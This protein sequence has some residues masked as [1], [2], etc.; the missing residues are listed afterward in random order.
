[1]K[2]A[3]MQ[4]AVMARRRVVASAVLDWGTADKADSRGGLP[5]TAVPMEPTMSE[6]VSLAMRQF[7]AW[8]ADRPRSYPE[9]REGWH[10]CPHISVWEDAIVDGLIRIEN[11]GGRAVTLTPR[12]RGLLAKS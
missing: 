6:P 10:S 9:A 5:Y 12:G 4:A 1:M 8:V 3:I 7:L 2:M 11:G